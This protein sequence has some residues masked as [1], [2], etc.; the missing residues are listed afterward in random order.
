MREFPLADVA[1][2]ELKLRQVIASLAIGT[3]SNV[4][5]LSGIQAGVVFACAPP[6]QK[7]IVLP[8]RAMT[9]LNEILAGVEAMAKWIREQHGEG[10]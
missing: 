7:A 10:A 9:T 5:P 3:V 2:T 4:R 6:G 8:D 1:D